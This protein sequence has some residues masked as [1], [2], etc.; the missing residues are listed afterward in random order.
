MT[1]LRFTPYLFVAAALGQLL[2]APA[3]LDLLGGLWRDVDGA[4]GLAVG[5]EGRAGVLALVP[6]ADAEDL[7]ADLAGDLVVQ[8]LVLAGIWMGKHLDVSGKKPTSNDG[9]NMAAG[10][11]TTTIINTTATVA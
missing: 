5:V 11:I 3:L 10:T 1:F 2:P 7:Q 8:H 9:I 4:D 6:R